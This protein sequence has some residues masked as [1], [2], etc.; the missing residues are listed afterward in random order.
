MQ[1]ETLADY[2]DRERASDDLSVSCAVI[3][4]VGA[5]PWMLEGQ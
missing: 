1:S 2:S 3:Q 5:D 4:S